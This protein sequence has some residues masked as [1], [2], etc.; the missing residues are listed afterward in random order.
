MCPAATLPPPRHRRPPTDQ[1]LPLAVAFA[2]VRHHQPEDCLHIEPLSARGQARAWTIPAH[3]HLGLHQLQWLGRG[4]ATLCLDDQTVMVQAPAALLLAPGSV[5]GFAY[6]GGAS[7]LQLTVPTPLVQQW[8]AQAPLLLDRLGRSQV[9]QGAALQAEA[10]LRSLPAQLVA[11]LEEFQQARPGRADA[12]KAGA[13]LALLAVARAAQALASAGRAPALRDTL[14]QRYRGLLEEGFRGAQ[15]VA[16]YAAELGVSADHLS[17][18]CRAVT[19][20]S[21]LALLHERQWLEARRLLAYGEAPVAEVARQL[22]FDDAGYFSRFFSRGCGVPPS[23]Y[24]ARIRQG[25]VAGPEGG[26]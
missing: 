18:S 13:L 22:G 23:A 3:R 7:G 5:H 15:P 24:R 17:R 10:A 25:L 19:G 2:E 9:F 26:G 21:A 6:A 1:R 20:Q 14:V 12:L 11:L 16:A 4:R 8:L